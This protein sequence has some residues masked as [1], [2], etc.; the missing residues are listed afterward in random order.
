MRAQNI[1]LTYVILIFG[2]LSYGYLPKYV[3]YG[4]HSTR[5][6]IFSSASNGDKFDLKH[7]SGSKESFVNTLKKRSLDER[8]LSKD[9]KVSISALLSQHAP[10]M[11]PSTIAIVLHSIGTLYSKNNAISSKTRTAD[12]R[13][14]LQHLQHN[15]NKVNEAD[16]ALI[17]VGLARL[18]VPWNDLEQKTELIAR[19]TSLIPYMD[20]RLVNDVVWAMGSSGIRWQE[21]PTHS[22]QAMQSA[23]TKWCHKMNPHSLSSA[24]W[25]LGKM[26]AKWSQLPYELQKALPARMSAIGS[27]FSPQQSSKSLWALGSLGA[28]W[29]VL[30]EGMLEKSVENVNKIK[31]SKTGSAVSASQTMTG[32]AKTGIQWDHMS[33]SMRIDVWETLER[34]CMSYN[35]RG[36]ANSVWALGTMAVPYS[37]QP[38]SIR[39][40]LMEGI[41]KVMSDSTAWALCNT[42]WGLS[43]MGYTWIDL[44][45][46]FKT[47][48]EKNLHRV[49]RE[50]NGIDIGLLLWS[51]GTMDTP[52]DLLPDSFSEP[53]LSALKRLLPTMKAQ[54]LSYAI[55]GMSSGGICWDMLP[56]EVK[57]GLNCALR[58]IG[59]S[60]SLQDMAST[61]HG[62]ACMCFDSEE[63]QEA[64]FRGVHEVMV[65]TVRRAEKLLAEESSQVLEQIR[66]FSHY[67]KVLRSDDEVVARPLPFLFFNKKT[68]TAPK[69]NLEAVPNPINHL[70][71]GSGSGSGNNNGNTSSPTISRLQNQVVNGLQNA[72]D[73]CT[74][75]QPHYCKIQHEY[76]AFDGLFPVDA[77]ISRHGNIIAFLE[78]DGPHHYRDD[79]RLRRR[80]LLKEGMYKGLY[81]QSDFH[82]I[83]WLEANKHGAAEVGADLAAIIIENIQKRETGRSLSGMLR[84]ATDV[85]FNS[86]ERGWNW[87]LRNAPT[88]DF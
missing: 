22:K 31:R 69:V 61:A 15:M 60:M 56:M 81:P 86:L 24:L 4:H 49:E 50:M 26:G 39:P 52:I 7:N 17:L 30:P 63:T 84:S 85:L 71:A 38:V 18:N 83:R 1:S 8:E 19:V 37:Q 64:S 34:V 55:W 70:P 46:E 16:I 21:L 3:S 5:G 27:D 43:K 87:S 54:D 23:I 12:S 9:E 79:G 68:T 88:K 36:I 53:I 13:L 62:L 66:I 57:W 77:A 73:T 42:V 72:L 48:L 75:Q 82:R 59:P 74:I 6:H 2:S 65:A 29:E 20:A 10:G 67:M 58:R 35:T 25:S 33:T 80:D 47:A 51:L 45:I 14:L 78:V 76:T 11:N 32:L 44:P 28:S 41:M 40:V